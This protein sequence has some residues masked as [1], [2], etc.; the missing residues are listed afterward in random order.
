MAEFRL[1]RDNPRGK[2]RKIADNW[3]VQTPPLTRQ[4]KLSF[5]TVDAVDTFE[6]IFDQP[7]SA[8]V[9]RI[10]LSITKSYNTWSLFQR[11][12]SP[13]C[14]RRRNR[15]KLGSSR[16]QVI[17]RS[18]YGW[19][20]PLTHFVRTALT[21]WILSRSCSVVS[22]HTGGCFFRFPSHLL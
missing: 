3:R 15:I 13:R 22:T 7:M 17:Y 19:G 2:C 4:S 14:P 10:Y 6:S 18:A 5:S 1:I 21:T 8:S 16:R 11:R 20:G 9:S 12:N